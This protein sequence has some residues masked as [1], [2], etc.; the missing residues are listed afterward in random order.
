MALE[1]RVVFNEG[2]ELDLDECKERRL[3]ISYIY[4]I[5]EIFTLYMLRKMKRTRMAE[6]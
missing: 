6:H 5:S 2:E 1:M 3:M 4:R